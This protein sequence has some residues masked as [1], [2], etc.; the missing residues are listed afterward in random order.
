VRIVGLWAV[1]LGYALLYTGWV[2]ARTSRGVSFAEVLTGSGK[3]AP[4]AAKSTGTPP[5]PAAGQTMAQ[6][7]AAPVNA[8][9]AWLAR[10]PIQPT[11]G[12]A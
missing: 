11:G 3:A 7:A 6:A 1:V 2:N 4:A 9:R 8:Q 10:Q 12:M 5:K